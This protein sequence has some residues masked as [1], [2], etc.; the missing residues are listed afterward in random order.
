MDRSQLCEK[1][2][3][4]N[5]I[6]D[7]IFWY[8]YDK[9]KSAYRSVK[10]WFYCNWNKYHWRL[11]KASFLSY[12][13]DE[14]FS[15]KLEYAQIE[16]QLYWFEKQRYF[17][18]DKTKL[19]IRTLKLAK[20]CLNIMIT[21]ASDLWYST[22]SF[23]SV[24]NGNGTFTL[25]EGTYEHHYN[26]PYVNTKNALRF[27]SKSMNDSIIA[28]GYYEELYLAKCRKLYYKIKEQYSVYWWD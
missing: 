19:T 6:D 18:T 24:D 2:K 23:D 16:K 8:I 13:W 5:W 27:I 22:G 3:W 17:D 26:G 4:Y 1:Y 10:H 9:P 15:L 25:T 28:R 20:Y 14:S 11:I 12:G 7:H 21:E